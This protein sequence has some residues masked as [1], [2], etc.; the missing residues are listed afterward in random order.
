MTSDH[1]SA[2]IAEAFVKPI[3]SVLI[4]DD[5]YPTFDEMLDK[6]IAQGGD[7]D[8][9]NSNKKWYD[10]PAR[11]KTV[12]DSFRRP[13]RP[14]LVDI[15]DGTNVDAHGD[16]KVAAHLHQSDLLVL[17]YELDKARPRD[18]RR[19]IDI[20]RSLMSNDHFNLVVVHTSDNLD[21]VHRQIVLGLLSPRDEQVDAEMEGAALELIAVREDA[22]EDFAEAF[23]KVI[24]EEQYLHARLHPESYL[25]TM[26]RKQQPYSDFAS[27]ADAAGWDNDARKLVLLHQLG[28]VEASL[29]GGMNSEQDTRVQWSGGAIRWI[30]SESIFVAFSSK[31]DH[32][33]LLGDLQKALEAWGPEPSRLFLAKL[34]AEM[35][36]YGVVAQSE[37]LERKHA[38]AHWYGRLLRAGG[39]ERR[40]LIAESVGRHSDQLL[41]II[42]PRVEKFATDLVEAETASGS[43]DDICNTHFGVDLTKPEPKKKALREHNAFVCSKPPQGWH[44][45]TG[46][47][48]EVEGEHWVCL[49]PA[50]DLVPGQGGAKTAIYG[51]RIP[52]VAV[53]LHPVGDG[54]SPD[55][56]TNLYVFLH[57]GGTIRAF[58]FNEQGKEAAAPIWRT[59]YAEKKGVFIDE[60]AFRI[61]S[62]RPGRR[63]LISVVQAA[64]IVAQLRY[65]Y[66]LNLMQKLGISMTRIGLDF[67]G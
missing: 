35:D 45:T 27:L 42:L 18:G 12:I 61:S 11:I 8:P 29:R 2:F 54:K 55:V 37:A 4:V 16:A 13:D 59:F 36:D 66:A 17:D 62:T 6:Q 20:L 46:H 65:E 51:D 14:L 63:R 57:L 60:F 33:D 44:L 23:A 1:Y 58:G 38:L 25:R 9:P 19:A 39:Q 32:D 3:R 50:C 24:G 28:R 34:R 26:G 56:N 48:F 5:D 22:D 52:F 41:H 31:D 21:Y 43:P 40:W 64:H 49:T 30:K 53:K 10:A 15:H 7:G 47:V 67:A